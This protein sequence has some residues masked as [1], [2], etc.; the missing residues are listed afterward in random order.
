M[1]PPDV[2][3]SNHIAVAFV[4]TVWTVEM[5]TVAAFIVV[6]RC[7]HSP[8]TLATAGTEPRRSPRILR[9]ELNPEQASLVLDVIEEFAPCPRRNRPRNS[10]YSLLQMSVTSNLLRKSDNKFFENS[11]VI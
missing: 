5:T 8:T 6:V 9:R 2:H 4:A 10:T 1:F 11:F 7:L 3:R